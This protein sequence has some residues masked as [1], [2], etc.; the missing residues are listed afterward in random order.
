MHI[1]LAQLRDSVA[2]FPTYSEAYFKAIE[3]LHA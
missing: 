3:Q 1:A 2:Q